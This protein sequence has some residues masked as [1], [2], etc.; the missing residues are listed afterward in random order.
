M[1]AD[2]V[3]NDDKRPATGRHAGSENEVPLETLSLAEDTRKA[4]GRD[5]HHARR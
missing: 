5:G 4:N 1:R 2:A 3:K